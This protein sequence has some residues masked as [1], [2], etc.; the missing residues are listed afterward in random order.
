MVRIKKR[1]RLWS[2][3]ESEEELPASMLCP[4]LSQ[5]G[6]KCP[7][8]PWKV[9]KGFGPFE[10]SLRVSGAG[11]GIEVGDVLVKLWN[12]LFSSLEFERNGDFTLETPPVGVRSG[13]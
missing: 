13:V 7:E 2:G 12:K 11:D 5:K 6:F 9:G 1:G 3:S 4:E 10:L 8:F